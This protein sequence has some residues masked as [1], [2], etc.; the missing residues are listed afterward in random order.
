MKKSEEFLSVYNKTDHYLRTF[1][2][3]D[4]Y[5]NFSTIVSRTADKNGV[6]KQ[7]KKKLLEY[8]D[9]R[10]AIVHERIDGKVIAEPNQYALD[11]FKKIFTKISSPDLIL[12][13]CNH[14]V[15][16]LDEGALLTE[17]LMI[18][19]QEDFSQI[20][21]YRDNTF[22]CMLNSE[23]ISSWLRNSIEEEMISIV[24]TTVKEV[25]QFQ[26]DNKKTIVKSRNINIYEII[27]LYK[28]SA[29]E[30]L[31]IDAILI[32]QNGKKNEKPLTIIT[33]SDI[34]SILEHF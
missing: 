23:I 22:L 9:L 18:M 16:I 1:D 21:I 11:D 7:Y 24:E 30:P 10:N 26:V 29:Y 12:S 4:K 13:I 33:D 17:A 27:D 8:N 5:V 32:T 25:I 6:V 3:T 19:K 15:K 28:K 31:Q 2:N 20:P 14:K 34:P